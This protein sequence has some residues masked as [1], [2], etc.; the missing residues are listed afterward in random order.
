MVFTRIALMKLTL[1][2][3]MENDCNVVKGKVHLNESF[4]AKRKGNLLFLVFADAHILWLLV[5]V[6]G[7]AGEI[8]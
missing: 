5:S 1:S 2:D 7:T 8:Q 4:L 6:A 3:H